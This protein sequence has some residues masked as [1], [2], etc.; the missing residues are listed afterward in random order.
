MTAVI[1]SALARSAAVDH[2]EQL[3]DVLVHR[4][5]G[6]LDQ[7]HVAAADVL[8]DLAGDFAVREFSQ[9]DVAQRNAEVVG[10]PFGKRLVGSAAEDL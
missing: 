9:R 10:D 2:H 5:A 7:E 1:R 4:R 8:V 3:H 6:G